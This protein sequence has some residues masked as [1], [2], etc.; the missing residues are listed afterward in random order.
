MIYDAKYFLGNEFRYCINREM[1]KT[2]VLVK[3]EMF[4][5]FNHCIKTTKLAIGNA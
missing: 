3:T 2:G 1:T 4:L 5:H